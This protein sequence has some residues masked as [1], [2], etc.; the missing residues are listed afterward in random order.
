VIAS[1]PAFEVGSFGG[2]PGTDRC[3]A[4]GREGREEVEGR[5]GSEFEGRTGIG[6]LVFQTV[7]EELVEGVLYW[8][9]EEM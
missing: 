1:T 7:L 9:G 6:L 4:A 2:R 5:M 8:R 3:R